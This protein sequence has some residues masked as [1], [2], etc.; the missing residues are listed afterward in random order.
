MTSDRLENLLFHIEELGPYDD[1]GY[2]RLGREI[3]QHLTRSEPTTEEER[4]ERIADVVEVLRYCDQIGDHWGDFRGI[5]ESSHKLAEW[6]VLA[7]ALEEY[8]PTNPNFVMRLLISENEDGWELYHWL[9]HDDPDQQV[10][11]DAVRADWQQEPRGIIETLA[12]HGFL[13]HALVDV[14]EILENERTFERLVDWTLTGDTGEVWRPMYTVPLLPEDA[15][16]PYIDQAFEMHPDLMRAE[17]LETPLLTKLLD[18]NG[19]GGNR[20]Q[21]GSL[22]YRHDLL[23]ELIQSDDKEIRQAAIRIAPSSLTKDPPDRS[24]SGGG[25]SR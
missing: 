24:S 3:A 16:L 1:Q 2:E 22:L 21:L 25:R 8:I 6:D 11:A 14:P 18:A 9:D 20:S 5:R 4:R 10:F 23:M 19:G 13:G 7:P 12:I 15:R 17:F